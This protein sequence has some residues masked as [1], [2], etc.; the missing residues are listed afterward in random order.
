MSNED[1]P[2]FGWKHRARAV[3]KQISLDGQETNPAKK[4]KND[5]ANGGRSG[6]RGKRE[7]TSAMVEVPQSGDLVEAGFQPRHSQ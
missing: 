6:M 5:D 7:K 2:I 1:D 4:S 3:G